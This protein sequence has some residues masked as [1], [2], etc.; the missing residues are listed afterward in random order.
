VKSHTAEKVRPYAGRVQL[1]QV[2]TVGSSLN[3]RAVMLQLY[4]GQLVIVE[5]GLP[6]AAAGVLRREVAE[7]LDMAGAEAA[8]AQRAGGGLNA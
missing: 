3:N 2:H 8:R 4:T 7:F 1:V 6:E 5:S